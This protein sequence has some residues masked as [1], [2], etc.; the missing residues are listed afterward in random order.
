MTLRRARPKSFETR[1]WFPFFA[2]SMAHNLDTS[3]IGI[4]SNDSMSWLLF[5]IETRHIHHRLF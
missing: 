4:A 1:V 5:N 3:T 2:F